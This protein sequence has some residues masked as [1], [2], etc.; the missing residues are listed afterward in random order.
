MNDCCNVWTGVT[1]SMRPRWSCHQA[2][3]ITTAPTT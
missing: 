2:R 1:C 3:L